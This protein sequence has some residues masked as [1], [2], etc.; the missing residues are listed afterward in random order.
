M[1]V[2]TNK[3]WNRE[4]WHK[5]EEKLR[6]YLAELYGP[7]YE[8]LRHLS[9]QEETVVVN[10]PASGLKQNENKQACSFLRLTGDTWQQPWYQASASLETWSMAS[11]IKDGASSGIRLA[12]AF[13]FFH[14][15]TSHR[16]FNPAP[17]MAWML[18]GY[19]GRTHQ[20]HINK[21][22][23]WASSAPKETEDFFRKADPV[24]Y[25]FLTSCLQ[26][27][28]TMKHIR[29]LL[30]MLPQ[31]AGL[32]QILAAAIVEGYNSANLISTCWVA[33]KA[34]TR[35][36]RAAGKLTS[37]ELATLDA[38]NSARK[39]K[40]VE[41]QQLSVL[42]EAGEASVEEVAK[43]AELEAVVDLRSQTR[44]KQRARAEALEELEGL[45]S[46]EIKELQELRTALDAF[47]KGR[48]D[49]RRRNIAQV[50]RD[51]LAD[52]RVEAADDDLTDEEDMALLAG[53][54]TYKYKPR[55]GGE[56]AAAK[57]ERKKT[58]DM[59]F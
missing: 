43:H 57:G 31:T 39:A 51:Y 7:D 49:L 52:Q 55:S 20:A 25:Y 38:R 6:P 54:S 32:D 5:F 2:D 12:T 35:A 47:N 15:M 33:Q 40:E 45:T 41:Y 36:R 58:A 48:E 50:R 42:V 14:L 11:L 22:Q 16:R 24:T 46:E 53:L 3:I 37:E 26:T 44:Q 8:R 13:T 4:R 28:K 17:T 10:A 27:E 23:Y 59:D 56:L 9:V 1:G 29:A 21:I 18:D 34:N 30:P 19:I